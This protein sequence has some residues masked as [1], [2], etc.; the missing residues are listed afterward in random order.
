[1]NNHEDS[2]SAFGGNKVYKVTISTSHTYTTETEWNVLL[3]RTL[4]S[5]SVILV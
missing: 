1:M 5:I 2:I 4:Y 3:N